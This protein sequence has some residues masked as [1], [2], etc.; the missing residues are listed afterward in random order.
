MGVWRGCL[1]ASG[2]QKFC[3]GPLL[4][5]GSVSMLLF[6]RISWWSECFCKWCWFPDGLWGKVFHKLKL[7]QP[8]EAVKSA[9]IRSSKI[10]ELPQNH[11]EKTNK[12]FL[13]PF[14]H[15]REAFPPPLP[16]LWPYSFGR[17][18][19]V[20]VYLGNALLPSSNEPK[21]PGMAVLSDTHF[22][23]C[24]ARE[25]NL[26]TTCSPLPVWYFVSL[27]VQVPQ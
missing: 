25:S 12:L 15:S 27:S 9:K 22:A 19:K 4:T 18:P 11:W 21:A 24:F 16:Y 8:Q 3:V 7:P 20:E 23:A 1:C 13:Y 17:Q 10:P 14:C 26:W 5:T 6:C 2:L